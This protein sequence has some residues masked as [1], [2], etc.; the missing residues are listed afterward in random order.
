[1]QSLLVSPN[2]PVVLT[3][4]LLQVEARLQSRVRLLECERIELLRELERGKLLLSEREER[5]V[6]EL[7]EI[8][9]V[10]KAAINKVCQSIYQSI[11]CHIVTTKAVLTCHNQICLTLQSSN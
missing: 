2:P 4:D 8:R 6:T 10:H 9:L 1:M 5:N 3:S 11:S 7:A